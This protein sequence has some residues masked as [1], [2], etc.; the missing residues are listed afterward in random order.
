[1]A[2]PTYIE[3]K[4]RAHRGLPAPALRRALRQSAGLTQEDLAGAIGVRRESVSRW[5]TG[6][7]TPRG[8]LLAAYTEL[9]EAIK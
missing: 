6:L 5:E 8:R 1:M 9:L 4:I 7:R 3:R 2:E